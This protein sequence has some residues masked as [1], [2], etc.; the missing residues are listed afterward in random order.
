M[1]EVHVAPLSLERL[2]SK[3]TWTEI[4]SRTVNWVW[5]TRLASQSLGLRLIPGWLA[6]G[7]PQMY[8]CP[9]S[10]RSLSCVLVGAATDRDDVDG[11]FVEE[12]AQD[13]IT[14][15]HGRGPYRPAPDA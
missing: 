13:G 9:P 2:A 6:L 15:V 10:S 3:S 5:A 1:Q 8:A 12:P 11:P 14:V 4:L 7:V